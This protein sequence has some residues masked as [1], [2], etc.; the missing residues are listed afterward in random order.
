MTGMANQHNLLLADGTLWVLVSRTGLP[1]YDFDFET[2][3]PCSHPWKLPAEI[4]AIARVGAFEDYESEYRRLEAD[5]I[6]LIHSPHQHLLCSQ[7][8][9]WY[10]LLADLTPRSKW[11]D[12]VPEA[13]QISA[14]FDWPVF[15]KGV[16]QTS[17]HRK[18]LSIIESPEAFQQAMQVY[19]QDPILRWQ[20][21]VC[22]E[23]VPLR[24]VGEAN[25][26]DRIPNSFEFRTFWWNGQLVGY[27]R[28]WWEQ[29][30]YGMTEV[31]KAAALGVAQEAARRLSV[32]FLVIDIAQSAE[33]KWIII[34]CNDA[35]ESGY[36]GAS[37]IGIWQNIVQVEKL[38]S[39]AEQL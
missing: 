39:I 24:P 8:P 28:Y 35:Q 37:P 19:R 31:E 20:R 4:S 17:H 10:P 21:I 23:Y 22:R 14:D 30:P 29:E 27:G 9:N 18:S 7:L 12:D 5:G 11:Y 16:R 3:M 33:G 32:P 34:E 38:R 1:I 26:E 15:V 2:F 36:A 6:R 13:K 25:L